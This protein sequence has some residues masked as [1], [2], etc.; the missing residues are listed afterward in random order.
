VLIARAAEARPVLPDALRERGAEV[1]DVAL[2]ETLAEPLT[3]GQRE[4]LAR[5]SYVT[6]TSSTTVRFFLESGGELPRSARIVS[7]GPVTSKTAR[8]L[9]LTVHVEAERHDI[10]GLVE[11]LLADAGES[12]P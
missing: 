4:Q 3:E 8:E 7:I 12:S 6:F 11:A 1:D 2:Y 9:G 5:T 10:D